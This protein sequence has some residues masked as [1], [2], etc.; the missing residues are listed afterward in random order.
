[1]QHHTHL[2][3]MSIRKVVM[4]AGSGHPSCPLASMVFQRLYY[5]PALKAAVFETYQLFY[6][7]NWYE[8]RCVE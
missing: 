6:F 4:V 3:P 5:R 8:M 7:K 2:E 1:M